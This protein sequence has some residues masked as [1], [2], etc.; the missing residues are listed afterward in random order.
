MTLALDNVDDLLYCDGLETMTLKVTGQPDVELLECVITEPTVYREM[1]PSDAQ[2]PQADQLAAW[3]VSRSSMP[4]L[5]GVLVDSDDVYW[6]ILRVRHK[7]HME[8][9]E[10]TCRNLSVTTGTTNQAT[11]LT[12]TYGHGRSGEAKAVWVGA[13]SGA[14][15]PTTADVFT[16]RF[17]P[18]AETAILRFGAEFTKMTYRV[19]FNEPVP[20]NVAGGE[21]R[22]VDNA[23]YRYR[24][25]EYAQE[26]RID[27]LPAAIA[28][29]ILEGAEYHTLGPGA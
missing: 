23:G 7:R 6:T 22:L 29:R 24:V 1:E 25:M 4:P 11:I 9:W 20:I 10:A 26:E 18:S 16:A 19:I 28:L 21:Y 15:T 27:K 5:G 2:V 12:A 17:Q 3:P 13:V 8:N 14:A